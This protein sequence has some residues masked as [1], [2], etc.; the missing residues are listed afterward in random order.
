[1]HL[2]ASPKDEDILMVC[3]VSQTEECIINLQS[4]VTESQF[5]NESSESVDLTS[6]LQE[7]WSQVAEAGDY[8]NSPTSGNLQSGEK[9]LDDVLTMLD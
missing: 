6:C 5:Y 9:S 1:M 8:V 4:A 2:D 3:F 7:T